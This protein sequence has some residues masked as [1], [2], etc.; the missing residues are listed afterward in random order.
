MYQSEWNDNVAFDIEEK[1]NPSPQFIS[2][3]NKDNIDKILFCHWEEHCLECA[4]PLCYNTCSLY[5]ERPD[6]KCRKVYY[7]VIKNKNFKG[8]FPFGADIKFRKWG[9]MMGQFYGLALNVDQTNKYENLN[10]SVVKKF[11]VLSSLLSPLDSK[12]KPNGALNFYRHK[13]LSNIKSDPTVKYDDF[14]IECFSFEKETFR[15]LIENNQYSDNHYRNSVLIVPGHNLIRIPAKS[16]KYKDDLIKGNVTIFPE[17]D[18]EVRLVFTWLDFVK[19]KNI[20]EN[21]EVK[22][23]PAEKIKCIAWDLDNTLWKGVFIESKPEDLILNQEAVNLIKK[24][25]ERGILQTVVS[26]NTHEDVWPFIQSLGLDQYF[27]YPG[28]NWGQKS[29]SLKKIADLLNIN[30]DTFGFIDDSP[31][32]RQE[33]ASA[34]SQIRV[35]EDTEI[36]DLINRPEF[37]FPITEESKNRRSYYLIEQKRTQIAETFAGDYHSFLRNCGIKLNVFTPKDPGHI[38][39]CY[40]LIQRTNQL[41]LSSRK[42]NEEEFK[43]IMEG[44]QYLKFAFDVQDQFG[45][46]GIVGFVVVE[47]GSDNLKIIDFV[48]S[49]RV[50]QKMIEDAFITWLSDKMRPEGKKYLLADYKKTLRNGKI[51]S[52]FEKINFEKEDLGNDLFLLSLDIE[53]HKLTNDVITVVSE[54]L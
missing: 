31:F 39:R 21:K 8:L 54:Q 23:K 48:I 38:I 30:I 7:G 42:Y 11:N 46:Y 12:K 16:F 27:L 52:V 18:K 25:D 45:S 41:N 9:K 43:R 40:E 49:C 26:K 37:D 17:N 14:I 10:L 19:Y 2:K 32:E 34:L 6:K 50:A 51:L 47:I 33:V 3:V 24:L 36:A 5:L 22:L 20:P 13:W 44:E 35:Y 4:P 15:L 53:K 29:E 28:I 1:N